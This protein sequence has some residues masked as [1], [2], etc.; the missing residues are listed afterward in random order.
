MNLFFTHTDFH[1]INRSSRSRGYIFISRNNRGAYS[2]KIQQYIPSIF[3]RFSAKMQSERE[4]L[5]NCDKLQSI[6]ITLILL[7][8]AYLE[9]TYTHFS[10]FHKQTADYYYNT[11]NLY[12]HSYMFVHN[13]VREL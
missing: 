5:C 3:L 8:V 13:Y 2:I 9:Q 1:D 7:C 4:S 11:V 12:T 10:N 6:R